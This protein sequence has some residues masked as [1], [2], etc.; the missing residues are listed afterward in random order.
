M[1][2]EC[3]LYIL[4]SQHLWTVGIHVPEL[5]LFISAVLLNSFIPSGGFISM[6]EWMKIHIKG[7]NT[8]ILSKHLRNTPFA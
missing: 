8:K 4:E 7:T 6:C 5:V 3:D 1:Y 2:K